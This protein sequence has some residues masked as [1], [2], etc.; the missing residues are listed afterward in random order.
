MVVIHVE[1][2]GS[3]HKWNP[4]PSGMSPVKCADVNTHKSR[5]KIRAFVI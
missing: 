3:N 4:P 2:S 5:P 1:E